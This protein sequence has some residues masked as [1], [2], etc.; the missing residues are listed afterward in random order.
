MDDSCKEQRHKVNWK[1]KTQKGEQIMTAKR[2]DEWS[3]AVSSCPEQNITFSSH[4]CW[5]EAA[6]GRDTEMEGVLKGHVLP[7][8]YRNKWCDQK[9]NDWW[10][11]Y[12]DRLGKGCPCHV[13]LA[14]CSTAKMRAWA[15]THSCQTWICIDKKNKTANVQNK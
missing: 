7:G 5:A 3:Y 11:R 1:E 10:I 14:K 13:S 9:I 8:K 2:K 6:T 4:I 12:G 15:W